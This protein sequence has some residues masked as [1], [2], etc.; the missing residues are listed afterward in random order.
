MSPF[1]LKIDNC[2]ALKKY[3]NYEDGVWEFFLFS[4]SFRKDIIKVFFFLNLM[5]NPKDA[6]K[7]IT[8]ANIFNMTPYLIPAHT[9]IDL[10][11]NIL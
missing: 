6:D 8:F 3:D 10:K 7:C 11:T 1:N 4:F 2:S 9:G 5:L